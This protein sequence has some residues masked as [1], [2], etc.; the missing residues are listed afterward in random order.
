MKTFCIFSALYLPHLGGVERYTY[1]LSK[2]LVALGHKVIVVTSNI[3]NSEGIEEADNIKIYRFPA[4]SLLNGRFPIPKHNT[5]FTRMSKSLSIENIDYVIVNTRFYPHSL[6]GV[7][8]SK[9][10][11][12]P[13]IV[14]EHGTGHFTVNNK[15]LDVCGH[16]YEHFVTA[17]IKRYKPRFYGV[18][19]ECNKWLSHFGIKATGVLYNAVDLNEINQLLENPIEDYRKVHD[20]DD[21]L[22]VVTYTGRLVEEKGVIKLIEAINL[23]DNGNIHLFIAGDGPLR[24]QVISRTNP[25]IHFLGKIDF[26]HV[27]ALLKQTDIF[28][29]P[30]EYPEGF[31]TSVLEA[32]ACGCYCIATE[33]GGSKELII[34][35]SYGLVLSNVSP[36]TI[37]SS[38]GYAYESLNYRLSATENCKSRL[39]KYFLWEATAR[40]VN[41]CFNECRSDTE[42]ENIVK[43]GR[44][45][46]ADNPHIKTNFC[47]IGDYFQTF[48]IDNLYR[49]AGI[50]SDQIINIGRHEITTYSGE[51]VLLPMQGWFGHHVKGAE[52]FPISRNIT[53]IFMGFHCVSRKVLNISELK[54]Y[55]PIGCR[56]EDTYH[57][58]TKN[59]VLAFVSGCMTIT[60]PYRNNSNKS[61]DITYLVDV[62]SSF[63]PCI[64][65]NIKFNN[66]VV[67]HEVSVTNRGNYIEQALEYEKKA[68]EIYSMY[69][70]S[71]GLIITSRLHCAGPALAMGIPVI[72]VKEFFDSRYTWIDKYT[73]FYDKVLFNSV[74]WTVPRN[75]SI[76]SSKESIVKY[77]VNTIKQ[78]RNVDY[79]DVHDLYMSRM[80]QRTGLPLTRRVFVLMHENFPKTAEWIREIMIGKSK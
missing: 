16:L 61:A 71:A 5:K 62:E 42:R 11:N 31:P 33:Y 37:A 74:D 65:Q 73:K 8:F 1:N 32:A 79:N 49:L 9:K 22:I 28:C 64:P 77:A 40:M 66:S 63:T 72:L 14:I 55:E 60:L 57:L 3:D 75:T 52:I 54:K 23:L 80:R 2:H 45:V 70:D 56:D 36:A 6:F 69:H 35:D 29:L 24:E 51:P 19:G 18:S 59:G 7:R 12:K 10:L 17:M 39:Y 30:T 47:N 78:G 21:D 20:I 43:Y 53:P 25:N 13:R 44:I 26:P 34:D 4:I 67:T 50:P 76:D 27:I 15:L 38:I 46:Y 58:L 68:N 41:K 48:A